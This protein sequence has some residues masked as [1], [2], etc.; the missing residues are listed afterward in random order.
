MKGRQQKL[1]N[2]KKSNKKGFSVFFENA[3]KRHTEGKIYSIFKSW[4][5]LVE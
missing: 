1:I 4:E 5:C 2:T 3:W